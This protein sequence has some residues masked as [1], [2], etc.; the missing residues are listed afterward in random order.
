MILRRSASSP[1]LRRALLLFICAGL[2]AGV[3][4]LRSRKR[5]AVA[6]PEWLHIS[7]APARERSV[8]PTDGADDRKSKGAE[9]KADE[10]RR[11]SYPVAVHPQLGLFVVR[12]KAV[13]SD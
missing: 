6:D 12:A 3:F 5:D 13:G 11:S 10:Q 2:A 7:E 4:L 8:K 1:V 9:D